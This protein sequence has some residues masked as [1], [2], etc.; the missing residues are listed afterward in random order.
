MLNK[1]SNVGIIANPHSGKDVRRIISLASSFSNHEKLLIL[2]RVVKGLVASKV[3]NVYLLKDTGSL[4]LSI[5]DEKEI[6]L[7][8]K[9]TTNFHL[10]DMSANGTTEDSIMAATI[11]KDLKVDTI[12][13]LGGDGTSRAV[14]KGCGKIPLIPLSTGTNNVFPQNIEG[15]IA[16]LAAGFYSK[17]PEFYFP[18]VR[19]TKCFSVSFASRKKEKALVDIALVRETYAGAKAVWDISKIEFLALTCCIPG[20][21]GLS[22]IG[23]SFVSISPEDE[24]GLFV[25][26]TGRKTK[27]K[28]IVMSPIAPGMV[29]P[30]N[31]DS[32]R[33]I[34][35]NESFEYKATTDSVVAFDGE[36]EVVLNK[37]ESFSITLEDN[38]PRVLDVYQIMK[39]AA[40]RGDFL[41]D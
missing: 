32:H 9:N 2:K 23:S 15:T 10:L 7:E 36:R 24:E 11:L 40:Q 31:V 26:L 1:N 18:Q 12:I 17:D 6:L 21:L 33:R 38:G 34:K 30:V 25:K 16:G 22:A 13:A 39:N 35:M 14:S 4:G 19:K 5:I 27:N 28:E 37:G 20:S 8:G 29:V 41:L 3:D